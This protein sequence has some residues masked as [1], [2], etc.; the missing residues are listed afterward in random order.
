MSFLIFL[1]FFPFDHEI[2]AYIGFHF[3]HIFGHINACIGYAKHLLPGFNS[4]LCPSWDV[5]LARRH[6]NA[7]HGPSSYSWN[8][9]DALETI[10][11]YSVGTKKIWRHLQSLLQMK[12]QE[13]C[14]VRNWGLVHSI[15][16]SPFENKMDT[17]HCPFHTHWKWLPG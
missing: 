9:H 10:L 12:S 14:S 15:S 17:L 4:E 1:C 5:I 2:N 7:Q 13:V 6:R 3:W 11:I 16:P 8:R